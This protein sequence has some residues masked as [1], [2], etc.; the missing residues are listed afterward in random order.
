MSLVNNLSTK[1]V[2]SPQH[3]VKIKKIRERFSEYLGEESP[4]LSLYK[5]IENRPEKYYSEDAF[6]LYYNFLFSSKSDAFFDLL[7]KKKNEM[8]IAFKNMKIVN[9]YSWHEKEFSLNDYNTTLSFDLDVCP[10][11]LK[12]IESIYSPLI[13]LVAY[14]SRVSR[15]KSTEGLKIY[16][17]V[18]EIEG[19]DYAKLSDPYNHRVR[20]A[21]AHGGIKYTNKTII[22]EDEKD[23]I[24]LSYLDFLKTV[25]D[26]V[27]CCNAM[28][29][30]FKIF[31][32]FCGSLKSE[33]P[34]QIMFEELESKVK[35]PF[36]EIYGYLESETINNESQ[37]IIFGKPK[38]T[39]ERK[40]IYSAVLT[41][42]LSEYYS[43][44]YDR[45]F[46]SISSELN[47]LGW[48]VFDGKFI[49]KHRLKNTET[50]DEYKGLI[51]GDTYNFAPKYVL[52]K[53]F[54]YFGNFVAGA[55]VH[56]PIVFED[57]KKNFGRLFFSVRDAAVH[58]NGWQLV[59]RGSIVVE[60]NEKID[61]ER[62][63]T[64]AKRIIRS[65]L[66]SAK[67]KNAKKLINLL[68]LGYARI[69]IIKKDYRKR[70]LIN[71]GLVEDLVG[72]IQIKKIRRIQAPDIFGSEIE[73][74]K[75]IRFAW[76]KK[77][78]ESMR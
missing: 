49:E 29:L 73:E 38:T 59:L 54:Y 70:K 2:M 62:I 27:D 48:A 76:N 22:F 52:P 34:L 71:I 58:R 69:A 43:P 40:V 1:S 20:N 24:E 28:V 63:K 16:N 5:Y 30:A 44:G 12:I 18:E 55:K 35:S 75:G 19:G 57:M 39:D 50:L 21:I 13:Y 14:K 8:N 36:W 9:D 42:I 11:Y 17:C 72:T 6:K 46:L 32:N 56:F 4:F 15:N 66:K 64:E 74:I 7:S 26:L 53:I 31:F 45:Y 41:G 51:I 47:G 3:N 67:K 78:L 10:A 33:M 25:D 23:T 60:D 65:C 68:P 37:L 77:W 61:K